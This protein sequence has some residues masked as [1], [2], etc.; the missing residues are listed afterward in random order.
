MIV[1]T[2]K[3]HTQDACRKL[4]VRNQRTLCIETLTNMLNS[5]I[6]VGD[7]VA[8]QAVALAI[9]IILSVVFNQMSQMRVTHEGTRTSAY[10]LI[11][12]TTITDDAR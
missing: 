9:E 5:P 6:A 12:G 7:S 3:H 4:A 8:K 2:T 10:Y 1:E 11:L